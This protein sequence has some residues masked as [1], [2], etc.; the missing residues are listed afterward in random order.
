MLHN[1]CSEEASDMFLIFET[2]YKEGMESLILVM[3]VV[4]FIDIFLTQ[5]LESL[6][7]VSVSVMLSVRYYMLFTG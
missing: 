3:E 5:L 6:P 2:S 4:L 1:M 7:S